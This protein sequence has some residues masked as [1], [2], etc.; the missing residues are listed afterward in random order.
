[1]QPQH[2][3]F[4]LDEANDHI[5]ELAQLIPELRILRDGIIQARDK[6]DVEE[7]TSFGTKGKTALDAKNTMDRHQELIAKFNKEFEDKLSFFTS[8]GCDL[9]SLEPG[10]VDF[11][12][13]RHDELIYLC[14]K[15]GEVTIAHWH[16]IE[17]GF[18]GRT[19]IE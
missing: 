9:K 19:P 14:W 2:K 12:S 10:L 13:M 18:G 11:Y 3:I 7:V 8:V 4:T 15:E 16:S 1:M 17:E 5:P 6:Y